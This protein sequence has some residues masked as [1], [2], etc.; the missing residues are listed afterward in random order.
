MSELTRHEW[1]ELLSGYTTSVLVGNWVVA[2]A[3]S[4]GATSFT[5]V[6]ADTRTASTNGTPPLV[7]ASDAANFVGARIVF[8]RGVETPLNLT[9]PQP[10]STGL[11]FGVSTTVQSV[12]TDLSVSPPVTTITL[13]DPVPQALAIGDTFTIFRVQ[14]ANDPLGPDVVL[15][16]TVPA[17][18]V[19]FVASGD[20][21]AYQTLAV[22]G[23][24]RINGAV[25]TQNVV[26]LDG[27]QIILADQALLEQ[28]AFA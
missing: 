20:E 2:A 18:T 10:P 22:A 9:D 28:G 23:T 16:V 21:Q 17:G 3:A 5:V 11:N 4:A 8:G 6:L 24:D 26:L 19:V 15:D 27:G 1:Q 14:P 12:V 25:Y 13:N 7:G